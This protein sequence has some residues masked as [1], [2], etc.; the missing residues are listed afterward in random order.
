MKRLFVLAALL[1]LPAAAPP[2]RCDAACLGEL[3]GR[4]MDALVAKRSAELPW[5]ERVRY[6]ENGVP[7]MIGDGLWGSVTAHGARPLVVADP[8][9]GNVAWFG[10]VEEHGQPGFQAMRLKAAGGRIAEIEVV[11][12]RKEGRPPFGDAASFA[13]DAAFSARLAPAERTSRERMI[14]LAR[15]YYDGKAT[16]RLASLCARTDT[17]S[18]SGCGAPAP[19]GRTRALR[20]PAVDAERGLVVALGMRDD[21]ARSAVTAEASYPRSYAFAALLRIKGGAIERIEEVSTELP[22]LMPSWA[23]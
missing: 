14:A 19:P 3:A 23:E 10:I 11:T 15:G 1:A 2:P 12:R 20:F 7:M 9:S 18:A 21:G 16:T 13:H 8:D 4:Y 17:G 5:A 22:Y 6:A